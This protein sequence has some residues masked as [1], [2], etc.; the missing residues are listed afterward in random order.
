MFRVFHALGL[1]S[2]MPPACNK[3][4][5]GFGDSWCL[6]CSPLELS[7]GLLMQVW[8]QPGLR[9]I[10]EETLLSGARLIR[11]FANIDHSLPQG[12]AGS[13]DRAPAATTK[14]RAARPTRSRSPRRDERPPLPRSPRRPKTEPVSEH[15]SQDTDFEEDEEE[16]EEN[17]PD[18][19]VSRERRGHDRPPE[20]EGPPPGRAESAR[21]PAPAERRS[22]G[23]EEERKHKKKKRDHQNRGR[24]RGGPRHQ[25]RYK[26]LENP[27]RRSHRKL[28]GD[29]LEL[30]A[31]LEDGLSRRF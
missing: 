17:K 14:A 30:A 15:E 16:E 11:A 31:S 7:Q 3:C 27:F 23:H 9:S 20:P 8:R 2:S 10:A 6:G 21:P 18:K 28:G 29:L 4:K 19:E 13:S 24:R 22:T 12:G 25:R 1:K 5:Q 26:D